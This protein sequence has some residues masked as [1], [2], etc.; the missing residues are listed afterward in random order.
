VDVKKL[1]KQEAKPRTKLK[2]KIE[3]RARRDLYGGSK[4]LE[5]TK[6]QVR[7]QSLPLLT[8]QRRY[9]F[10]TILRRDVYESALST[11]ST[12]GASQSWT[13][14][15]KSSAICSFLEDRD[16]HLPSIDVS[17]GSNRILCASPANLPDLAADF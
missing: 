3:R 10:Q 6:N 13:I 5:Q 7:L 16:I 15:D 8:Y 1:E 2:A 11:L 9:V 4:L 17:F 12:V 14:L